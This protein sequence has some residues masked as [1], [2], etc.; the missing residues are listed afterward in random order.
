MSELMVKTF[1]QPIVLGSDQAV[2]TAAQVLAVSEISAAPVRDAV[3][4]EIE[5]LFD[6]KQLC[7]LMDLDNEAGFKDMARYEEILPSDRT[8]GQVKKSGLLMSKVQVNDSL[9]TA[10]EWFAKGVHKLPV[11]DGVQFEGMISQSD[12]VEYVHDN[13]KDECQIVLNKTLEELSIAKKKTIVLNCQ[14]RVKDAVALMVK[15]NVSSVGLLDTEDEEDKAEGVPLMGIISLTDIK[16]IF[17]K[18]TFQQFNLK[19][20]D[21][22]SNRLQASSGKTRFPVYSVRPQTTLESA[23]QKLSATRSHRIY[24]TEHMDPLGVI[25]LTDIIKTIISAKSE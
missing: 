20:C 22:I 23:I 2:A 5:Y 4:G 1:Q 11:F 16:H 7:G 14:K 18:R 21:F 12:W 10:A 15:E 9:W 6:F 25:S 24:V 8:I 19:L 13:L 17:H 3:S